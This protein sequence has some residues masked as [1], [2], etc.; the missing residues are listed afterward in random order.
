MEINDFEKVKGVVTTEDIVEGRFVVLGGAHSETYGFGS[1]ED[2]QGAKVPHTAEEGLRAKYII[3]WPVSNG[4][5]PIYE[6]TPSYP[7]SLRQGFGGAANVPFDA[8][9]YLTYPGY[10]DGETI[11]SGSLALAFTEGTFTIPSGSYIYGA[12]IIVPGAAL[13]VCTVDGDTTNA[14]KV[15]YAAALAVGVIG[16]TESWDETTGKLTVRVE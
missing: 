10:T 15:K 8:K 6:P 14:G 5:T 3:T 2:L 11:P 4:Q 16:F 13:V 12:N 1:R 9:V 7:F